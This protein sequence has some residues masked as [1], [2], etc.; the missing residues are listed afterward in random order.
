MRGI[1][2]HAD[3]FLPAEKGAVAI[4]VALM[5]PVLIGMAA[6]A[7]DVAY[8]R[9]VHGQ[10]QMAADAAALAAVQSLDSE[11]SAI[12]AA[13]EFAG[14]NVPANYGVVTTPENVEL[15]TYDADTRMFTPSDGIW[16]DINAVRV[17]AERSP[18]NG[19]ELKRFLGRILGDG[20]V[21]AR[22][23]AVAARHAWLQYE[24]PVSVSLANEAGDFNEMYAYCFDY[25]GAGPKEERRS[26][27]TLIANNMPLGEVIKDSN[28]NPVHERPPEDWEGSA[29]P[30][31]GEGESLSFHLR[32][33]RH[34][35]SDP[36]VW[37]IPEYL[38]DHEYKHYTDT[39]IVDGKEGFNLEYPILETLRCDSINECTPGHP[40]SVLVATLC[41]GGQ[42]S[43]REDPHIETRPCAPGKF[44]Y[45]GWEDR[46]FVGQAPGTGS[47]T[48]PGWTDLDYDDIRILMKCP[49]T[50]LL[51]DGI[52]RLVR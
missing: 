42:C 18:A 7:V 10:L 19:N 36:K 39:E 25:K 26:K 46:P 45:F 40:D 41:D 5:A 30:K 31:C 17:T 16:I 28:K 12:S 2:H 20:A 34:A 37:D 44:M 49:E 50:G 27:M 6:L 22:A 38:D 13:T 21:S 1:R 23:S 35:K 33:I 3:R 48:D 32:N 8:Y 14:R 52:A 15:G 4:T 11:S 43:L 24:P 51:G 29:W 9:S 47:W